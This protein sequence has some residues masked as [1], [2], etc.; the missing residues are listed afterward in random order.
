MERNWRTSMHKA[1]RAPTEAGGT[2]KRVAQE[3][4]RCPLDTPVNTFYLVSKVRS[5]Q[6]S[7]AE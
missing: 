3:S 6:V 4:V 5:C 7:M 2:E 1:V